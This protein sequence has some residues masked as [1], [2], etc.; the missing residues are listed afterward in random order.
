MGKAVFSLRSERHIAT[1]NYPKETRKKLRELELAK[2]KSVVDEVTR[3]C[4]ELVDHFEEC[5][6]WAK[7][8][9]YAETDLEWSKKL[10]NSQRIK[11]FARAHNNLVKGYRGCEAWAEAF[12]HLEKYLDFANRLGDPVEISQAYFD[13]GLT[14]LA[15]GESDDPNP[16]DFER[17]C[18]AFKDAR[19]WLEKSNQ[20]I[21]DKL[22][23]RVQMCVNIAIASSQISN[24]TQAE[25]AIQSGI[26]FARE[27][28]DF[29]ER[30][31]LLR[32]LYKEYAGVK[33]NQGDY[34]GAI[35][36]AQ[37]ELKCIQQVNDITEKGRA[38]I[39]MGGYFLMG[40]QYEVALKHFTSA[41]E[42]FKCVGDNDGR[43]KA[44]DEVRKTIAM[45]E[46]FDRVKSLTRR[47]DALRRYKPLPPEAIALLEER[48]EAHIQILNFKSGVDDLKE[49]VAASGGFDSLNRNVKIKIQSKLAEAYTSTRNYAQAAKHYS[50][51]LSLCRRDEYQQ[52]SQLLSKLG[53]VMLKAK[54]EYAQ[55]VAVFREL[56]VVGETMSDV[57]IQVDALRELEWVHGLHNSTEEAVACRSQREVLEKLL[58]QESQAADSE[59]PEFS[60]S[61]SQSASQK[62]VCSIDDQDILSPP[63]VVNPNLKFSEPL[64]CRQN[65]PSIRRS[66]RK[67]YKIFTLDSDPDVENDRPFNTAANSDLSPSSSITA[68]NG[69]S[70]GKKRRLVSD[71]PVHSPKKRLRRLVVSSSQDDI[72]PVSSPISNRSAGKA[73]ASPIAIEGGKP[74]AITPRKQSF[75]DHGFESAVLLTSSVSPKTTGFG[76]TQQ[77]TPTSTGL[78]CTGQP[79]ERPFVLHV[80]VQATGGELETLAIPCPSG[81]SGT[82]KTV[83]WLMGE[84][85]KRY[86]DIYGVV[87]EV[88]KITSEDPDTGAVC[89]LGKSD[90]LKHVLR[91]KQLVNAV[92]PPNVGTHAK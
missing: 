10:P 53:E 45:L 85:Q 70:T 1:V 41:V 72:E 42:H 19:H 65:S 82:P 50:D 5:G 36:M 31:Y 69:S 16:H 28:K 67:K 9:K 11:G 27:L 60:H 83:R 38:L 8:V 51:V 15:H 56:L 66:S 48:G 92:P 6:D 62:S 20:N 39:D 68:L 74:S 54:M 78:S 4:E 76:L 49:R 32:Q 2:S 71:S 17:A 88:W 86:K 30:H 79:R 21:Q 26:K 90:P 80:R 64:S 84:T 34:T 3:I 47:I 40:L 89:T 24:I 25:T 87:P 52:R 23:A 55:I 12:A 57:P 91:N 18:E 37:N 77:Q 73:L 44:E 22:S 58:P 81:P 14:F 29:T 33:A 61:A 46:T 7:V 75:H 43:D 35:Q 13:K 59:D 63:K